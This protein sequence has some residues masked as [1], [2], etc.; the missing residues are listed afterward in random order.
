MAAVS[1]MANGHGLAGA[2]MTGATVIV[3]AVTAMAGVTLA[4]GPLSGL[5]GERIGT[6]GPLLA[7]TGSGLAG[8]AMIVAVATAMAGVASVI[9]RLSG[10]IVARTGA[11]GAPLV[12]S[13][14]AIVTVVRRAV[15]IGTVTIGGSETRESAASAPMAQAVARVLSVGAVSGPAVM[16]A[17]SGIGASAMGASAGQAAHA[18]TGPW[19][20]AEGISRPAQGRRR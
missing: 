9:G 12:G 8:A 11:T 7:E 18:T 2:A 14:T 17:R 10:L 19:S 4:I 16:V 5:T 1:A 20:V 13:G 3:A 15:A 6:P